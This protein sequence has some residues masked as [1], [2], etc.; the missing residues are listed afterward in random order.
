MQNEA[1]LVPTDQPP[2]KAIGELRKL[3]GDAINT[4][5][6]AQKLYLKLCVYIRE[7]QLS[8]AVVQ[9]EL[10]SLGYHAAAIARLNSIAN[11]PTAIFESYKS[12][13]TSFRFTLQ[14]AREAKR[15]KKPKQQEFPSVKQDS[16]KWKLE[17]LRQDLRDLLELFIPVVPRKGS[18]HVTLTVNFTANGCPCSLQVG[19]R[20]K[21]KTKQ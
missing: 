3:A 9:R 18:E 8:P 16:P 5:Q 4:C 10:S 15:E 7:N 21:T 13:E 2:P 19:P 12:E 1:T 17:K 11:A 6:R 14:R 20:K